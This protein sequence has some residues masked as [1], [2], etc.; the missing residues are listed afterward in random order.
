MQELQKLTFQDAALPKM[1]AD[2]FFFE[3]IVKTTVGSPL[4]RYHTISSTITR[5]SPDTDT[6]RH[7]IVDAFVCLMQALHCTAGFIDLC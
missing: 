2:Q 3:K 4:S 6:F 7:I 1:W 5:M